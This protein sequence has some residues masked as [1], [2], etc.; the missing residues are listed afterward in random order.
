MNWLIF[1]SPVLLGL[2]VLAMAAL[3]QR[4]GWDKHRQLRG[5][6][7]YLVVVIAFFLGLGPFTAIV[8]IILAS[9]AGHAAITQQKTSWLYQLLV[10]GIMGILIL[11]SIS[12]KDL[13]T[14]S[15]I[16]AG[17]GVVGNIGLWIRAGLRVHAK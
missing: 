16:S 2:L 3:E 15:L 13:I 10:V 4:L 14:L 6:L 11:A 5:L 17:I 12:P 1:W 8:L 9:I 7:Y